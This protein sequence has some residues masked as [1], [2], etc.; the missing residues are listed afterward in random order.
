MGYKTK[1]EIQD[2]E[3]KARRP[4]HTRQIKQGEKEPVG[5]SDDGN[6]QKVPLISDDDE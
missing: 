5:S 2:A 4:D 3:D 1:D 6:T